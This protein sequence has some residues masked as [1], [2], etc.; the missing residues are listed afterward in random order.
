M[1]KAKSVIIARKVYFCCAHQYLSDKLSDAKNHAVF[2]ACVNV[3]GHDYTLEAYF[4]GTVDPHSGLVV[5]LMDIDQIL[6]AVV[7][8]LDHRFLNKDVDYFKT[9]IPTTE[10][11]ARY[12]FEQ[13]KTQCQLM[14]IELERVRLI[15]GQDLWTDY[16]PNQE[17]S[18]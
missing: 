5:N 10:N 4:S 2:G 14:P 3:H 18:L 11:I 16:G 8:P 9:H 6:R 7:Q 12:C 1:A 17:L 15:E 13:I